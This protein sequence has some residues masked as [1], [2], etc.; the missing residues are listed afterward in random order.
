MP[1]GLI[2]RNAAYSLRRRV[3][4]DLL[5]AYGKLEIVRALGTKDREEAKR[6]HAVAWVKL[7]QE[8]AA[9][10]QR[11]PD[12]LATHLQAKIRQIMDARKRNPLPVPTITDE[13]LDDLFD[14][15]AFDSTEE[16]REEVEYEERELDRRRLEAVLAVENVDA[17]GS[18][19]KALRDLLLSARAALERAEE[20]ARIAERKAANSALP[21]A[22]ARPA[23]LTQPSNSSLSALVDRWALERSPTPKTVRA[24]A[25][26]IRWFS[27]RTG[28]LATDLVTRTHV[29]AFKTALLNEGASAANIRTKLSR[30]RTILGFAVSEGSLSINP[31]VG[32]TAPRS[33]GPNPRISWATS[34][35][36]T[37]F[38]GPVH[39]LGERPIRGRGEAAYWM[40]L[41]ALFTGA[42]REE[43]GQLKKEDVASL[44]YDAE[45]AEREAWFF[46]IRFDEQ[47]KNQ[48][49]TASSERN[50]PVH[51][52]LIELGILELAASRPAGTLLFP[53]LRPNGDGKL[54]EKWGQWFTT[55]RQSCGVTDPRIKFHCFRH[56]FKDFCREAGIIEGVQ[57]QLMGH[58]PSDVPSKYGSGFSAN[59]LVA[60]IQ[61]Y[62]IPGLT[63]PPSPFG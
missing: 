53:E 58:K 44:V 39:Q 30:L 18:Q 38:A 1:T 50:V 40:P 27:E 47:G 37:L 41:L 35:L 26:V 54:T 29:Q 52:S 5:A 36:A 9:M 16:L 33:K 32:V 11:Q 20:R 23:P 57:R 25:A 34:D 61:S 21:N 42:R 14:Q 55:Y 63:L 8:F 56:A 22:V 4:K 46:R 28:I 62:R 10:R 31:A 59:M 6:L 2:R 43:L 13:E 3:P 17:L 12:D 19:D 7:D 24:H 45:G 49:K 51:P 15:M 60:A 48:L